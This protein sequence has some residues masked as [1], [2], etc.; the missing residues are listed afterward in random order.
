[1][2]VKLVVQTGEREGQ[3]IFIDDEELVIGRDSTC[4]FRINH[5]LVS[6]RHCRI[7]R[8]GQRVCV[9]DLHSATGT[10]VNDQPIDT[11]EIRDGDRI[12]VGSETFLVSIVTDQDGSPG[13]GRGR[14]RSVDGGW[15]KLRVIDNRGIATVYFTD[16]ALIN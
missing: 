14:P 11:T 7:C 15:T 16:I 1:M 5:Y 4:Q 12:K 10:K 6:P 2:D 9:K 13:S 3:E 8:D